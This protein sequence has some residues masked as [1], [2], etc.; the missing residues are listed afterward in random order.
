ME[1]LVPKG[2]P[3]D[4]EQDLVD[5]LVTRL[6]ARVTRVKL[7]SHEELARRA[8][9]VNCRYFDGKL[10]VNS[11]RYVSNQHTRFGSCT[12]STGAI[13]LSDRLTATPLW[14]QDYVLVHELA[15]LVTRTTHR[16]SGS[17]CTTIASPSAPGAF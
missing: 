7:R 5:R 8:P 17:S 15:H 14:V 4:Q 12:P 11:V 6:K 2:L 16:S 9:G 13:R 1:V 3:P 10:P